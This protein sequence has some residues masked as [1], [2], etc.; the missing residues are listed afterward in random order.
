[1]GEEKSSKWIEPDEIELT[2]TGNDQCNKKNT[3]A[4][5]V[6]ASEYDR[7][8]GSRVSDRATKRS[9]AN[10]TVANAH[11]PRKTARITFAVAPI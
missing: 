2:Q 9:S 11:A 7:T 10:A 4:S 1:M 6:A 3:I 5:S 8:F